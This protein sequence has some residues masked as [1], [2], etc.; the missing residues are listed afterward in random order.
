MLNSSEQ[1][2]NKCSNPPENEQLL[3]NKI[4]TRPSCFST[5]PARHIEDCQECHYTNECHA[6]FNHDLFYGDF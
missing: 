5:Q 1:V 3:M 2:G 4:T 6:Q